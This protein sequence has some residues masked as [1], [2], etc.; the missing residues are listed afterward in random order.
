MLHLF[1][2]DFCCVRITDISVQWLKAQNVKTIILD[3]DNT[4]LPWDS[5]A[6]TAENIGWIEALK[7]AGF[8]LIL[9]SNNGGRRLDDICRMVDLPA[10]SWA[11]KPLSLG[12]R[13]ALHRMRLKERGEVLVIG[14]QIITDVLGAKQ[15]GLKVM[16]VESLSQKEFIVTRFTRKVEHAV[17]N[18][19]V[20]KGLMPEGGGK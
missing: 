12:F 13:R 14:D 2:P 11:A 6:P 10:I 17:I 16:L 7:S 18:K 1:C 5:T 4:L 20:H 19:L 9:L 8:R 15:L 3:V